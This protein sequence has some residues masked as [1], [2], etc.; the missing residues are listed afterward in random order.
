MTLVNDPV[1]GMTLDADFSPLVAD[2]G[3][4]TYA[5]CSEDCRREFMADPERFVGG[6][7]PRPA[8]QSE[9]EVGEAPHT[10]SGG[11]T[12]P[13]FGSAGSGGAEYEPP[14]GRREQAR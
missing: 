4:R 13:K 2:Y 6:R 14:P 8:E 3:P 11:V 7:R 12:S 1:C 9:R 5:F 10:T